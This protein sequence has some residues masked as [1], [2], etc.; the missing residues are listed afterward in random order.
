VQFAVGLYQRHP[1]NPELV[2]GE[3]VADFARTAETAGFGAVYLTEHPIPDDEWLDSGGHDALDPFVG[4]AFAA[5]ATSRIRLL[6]NLTVLPY[7]NPFLLAK[8]VATLDRL[9]GG[10]VILGA[11]AGYLGAEYS[12]LGVDFDTRN[13]RFDESLE[14]LRLAWSGRSVVYESPRIS[15][16][17]NTALPT[18]LQDVVPI[19]IGGNSGLTLRRV[20]EHAQGWMPLPNPRSLGTRRRSPALETLDDLAR[21]LGVLRERAASVGRTEP[22]DVM[23]VAL[24]GGIPGSPGWDVDAY[25]RSLD[26]QEE[27][28][29]TW[30]AVNV[31]APSPGAALDVVHAFGERV[32]AARS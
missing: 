8:T 5:A 25:L 12:A 23:Y 26:R 29:V 3:V 14:V 2:T 27:L 18:P 20:A 1:I 22:I 31:S 4:L 9:S 13:D 28:G 17:G 10:R 11:G 6:T 24:D 19:W 30:N 16:T 21:L 7:R 32:I 15:A